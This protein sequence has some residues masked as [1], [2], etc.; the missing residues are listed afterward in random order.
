MIATFLILAL[1][2]LPSILLS[3]RTIAGNSDFSTT[4]TTTRTTTHTTT[5]TTTRTITRTITY[6]ITH[7]PTNLQKAI[8][9]KTP[10][11]ITHHYTNNYNNNYS[12]LP[13]KQKTNNRY[14]YPL[15]RQSFLN[16]LILSALSAGTCYLSF[17][18]SLF[19]TKAIPITLFSGATS[20][21]S[22]L[23]AE[24]LYRKALRALPIRQITVRTQ[25]DAT[26]VTH[27]I[28]NALTL[29]KI[30]TSPN[31]SDS[32]II[33]ILSNIDNTYF[34]NLIYKM[35]LKDMRIDPTVG[36]NQNTTGEL[37]GRLNSKEIIFQIRYDQI[38]DV[39]HAEYIKLKN[40]ILRLYDQAADGVVHIKCVLSYPWDTTPHAV[41][42]SLIKK[43][44]HNNNN[45]NMISIIYMDS[46]NI[47]LRFCPQGVE[48]IRFIYDNLLPH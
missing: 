9:Y 36:L 12:N 34:Y 40:Q 14:Y 18:C 39:T 16:P 21:G 47:P 46:N 48:Y 8:N 1:L 29:H 20:L 42:I 5:R 23:Y 37:I 33:T 38:G 6:P 17:L 15:S 11:T 28:A 43:N 41:I 27:A 19:T 24:Y 25:E 2:S 22:A 7:K 32:D 35:L 13:A 31:I 3:H 44:N 4:H 45:N 10:A 26:C 30:V